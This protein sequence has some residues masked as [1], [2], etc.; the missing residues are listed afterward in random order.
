MTDCE[1]IRDLMPDLAHGRGS[2]TEA[3]R[4][5]V[6][7]CEDCGLEWRLVQAGAALHQDAVVNTAAIAE[8]LRMR[9][10]DA[11]REAPIARLPWRGGRL[12]LGLLAAAAS[13]ALLIGVPGGRRPIVAPPPAAVAVLPEL[14]QLS[15]SQLEAVLADL[16]VLDARVSPMRLPRLGDLTDTELEQV[17][18]ALEG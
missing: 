16:D 13:I 15:E 9:I 2:W 6:A 11:P 4:G 8:R 3:E 10:A 18:R 7:G 14:D 1:T 5:H 17:L 12:A